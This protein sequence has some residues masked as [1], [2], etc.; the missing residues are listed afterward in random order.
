MKK[1]TGE[2]LDQPDSGSYGQRI[3]DRVPLL[4]EL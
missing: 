4:S 2:I 3:R 1:R